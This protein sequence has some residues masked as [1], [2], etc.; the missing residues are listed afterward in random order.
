LSNGSGSTWDPIVRV[1]AAIAAASF[2]STRHASLDLPANL[3]PYQDVLGAWFARSG[4]AST[5]S[6]G[7]SRQQRAQPQ[8]DQSTWF[9]IWRKVDHGGRTA[10]DV[11]GCE[12]S[13]PRCR[14]AYRG[15]RV[16][17]FRNDSRRHGHLHTTTE[18]YLGSTIEPVKGTNTSTNS[19]DT[20]NEHARATAVVCTRSASNNWLGCS[21]A[22]HPQ[23]PEEGAGRLACLHD[24]LG[25]PTALVRLTGLLGM[26]MVDPAAGD[27][28]ARPSWDELASGSQVRRHALAL[29]KEGQR[30]D[31]VERL[32]LGRVT[33]RHKQERAAIAEEL[34]AKP[35]RSDRVVNLCADELL[36]PRHQS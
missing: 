31:I 18:S 27:D 13:R 16:R 36:Y 32:H 24:S 14:C 22:V 21:G 23:S 1:A 30:K 11:V 19:Q 20:F 35:A 3:T 12:R 7:T 28:R 34:A 15:D 6:S 26:T 10:A 5:P 4:T 9:P 2:D 33:A 17:S 8:V 25:D 29:V